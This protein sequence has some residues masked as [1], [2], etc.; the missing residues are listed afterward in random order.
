[1]FQI[2]RGCA[3][4]LH[5]LLGQAITVTYE[6]ELGSVTDPSAGSGRLSDRHPSEQ[7]HPDAPS[8]PTWTKELERMSVELDHRPCRGPKEPHAP[9]P[10]WDDHEIDPGRWFCDGITEADPEAVLDEAIDAAQH[11]DPDLLAEV[12]AELDA[13][14]PQR[15]AE[16]A[17]MLH[18]DRQTGEVTGSAVGNEAHIAPHTSPLPADAPLS[19]TPAREGTVDA[20]ELSEALTYDQVAESLQVE[21]AADDFLG[22]VERGDS[23]N[24]PPRFG[25]IV[26]D[27]M[28]E[29]LRK[30]SAETPAPY[31]LA[32]M[33]ATVTRRA[34][35]E[36][37][38]GHRDLLAQVLE[39]AFDAEDPL[40]DAD[41]IVRLLFSD[42]GAPTRDEQLQSWLA[43][44]GSDEVILKDCLA[45]ARGGIHSPDGWIAR[46]CGYVAHLEGGNPSVPT[47]AQRDT[48]WKA[49]TTYAHDYATAKAEEAQQSVDRADERIAELERQVTEARADRGQRATKRGTHQ[50]D[51]KMLAPSTEPPAEG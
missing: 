11:P 51:A 38:S 33:A 4:A 1:M 20:T 23:G 25:G 48:A 13:E 18:Q 28:A 19:D 49:A 34:A 22:F 16:P 7:E 36:W 3:Q 43:G 15:M 44:D 31:H 2:C 21:Q 32:E 29:L 41:E 42:E 35:Q 10:W 39:N 24:R 37:L 14:G 27:P 47:P 5:Q 40:D 46:F 6:G 30:D 17:G 9:H 50:A 8:A 12:D 26:Q 45:H